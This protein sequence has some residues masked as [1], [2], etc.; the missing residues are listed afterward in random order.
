MRA[1]QR[2]RRDDFLNKIGS[3]PLVMGIL[4]LTPDSFSDG[5]Q[6]LDT[7]AALA[8]AKTMAADGCDIIDVGGESTR[9]GA[10]EVTEAEEFARISSVLE[11]LA[12]SVD[13]PISIDTYKSGIAA[14]AMDLG[15]VVVNDIWGLQ[16]DPAMAD[17]VAAAQAAV[18]VMHNRMEKDEAIDILSDMRRF[19]DISLAL[20]AK[21]GIRKQHIILDPGIGFGKTARQNLACVAR[22]GE[23][24]DYRMPILIGASR[25]AFLRALLPDLREA[26]VFGTVAVALAAAANGASIFRVHDVAAHVGALRVFHT[27]RSTTAERSERGN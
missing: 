16:K 23:L 18:V 7:D 14:K 15:A 2:A 24:K 25:K 3:R 20:A 11:A 26:T 10:V 4:N 13:I 9:P 8:H 21:A 1:D 17:T 6:F 12:R 27:I 19:F 5:G 22:L